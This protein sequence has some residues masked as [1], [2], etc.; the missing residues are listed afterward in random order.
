MIHAHGS[1]RFIERLLSLFPRLGNTARQHRFNQSRISFKSRAALTVGELRELLNKDER[2]AVTVLE[3]HG[4]TVAWA[5]GDQRG[6]YRPKDGIQTPASALDMIAMNKTR[7]LGVRWYVF[8]VHEEATRAGLDLDIVTLGELMKSQAADGAR[9][10]RR[11]SYLVPAFVGG[12]F[13]G[14]NYRTGQSEYRVSLL[15][16]GATIAAKFDKSWRPDEVEDA[17][18]LLKDEKMLSMLLFSITPNAFTDRQ[19]GRE[20]IYYTITGVT[21]PKTDAA[22]MALTPIDES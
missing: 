3:A 6:R 22:E 4:H 11:R 15:A 9:L 7:G 5:D 8:A 13:A 20:V 14:K 10:A 21:R 2:E 16:D 19:T 17:A 1:E 12:I 18:K